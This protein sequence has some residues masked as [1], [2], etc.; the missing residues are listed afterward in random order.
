MI[1]E[2]AANIYNFARL[3]QMPGRFS[4]PYLIR[5]FVCWR[6]SVSIVFCPCLQTAALMLQI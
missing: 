4:V 5:P 3:L 6:T 2:S 1:A